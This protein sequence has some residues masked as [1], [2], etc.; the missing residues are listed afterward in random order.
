[1]SEKGIDSLNIGIPEMGGS[2]W[3]AGSIYTYN[4]V[5]A[6]QLIAE[7]K[8]AKAVLFQRAYLSAKDSNANNLTGDRIFYSYVESF[9]EAK[10]RRYSKWLISKLRHPRSVS[11]ERSAQKRKIDF[12]FPLGTALPLLKCAQAQW[13]PDF[14]H[15]RLPQYFPTPFGEQR[16]QIVD[17][18]LK[19]ADHIILSSEAARRDAISYS[20][21]CERKLKVLP[22]V[23]LPDKEWFECE[24]GPVARRYAG[25]RPFF[26]FPSQ[27]W[28][29]KGHETLIRAVARLKRSF[30]R[31]ITVLC[32]GFQLDYRFPDH[33]KEIENLVADLGLSEQ[34]RFLG[35]LPRTEQVQLVRAS[36]AVIQPSRFEGWSALLEDAQC[37]GKPIIATDLEVHREQN[38]PK[39]QYFPVGDS[40]ALASEIETFLITGPRGYDKREEKIGLDRQLKR[41]EDFANRFIGIASKIV[42]EHAALNRE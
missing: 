11:F 21:D 31:E 9:T 37:L 33:F 42:E 24:P 12:M 30:D 19:K 29:H 13:I 35:L 34:V 6:L 28:A 32:T 8:T 25:G 2:G 22:F 23:I 18:V 4:L 41:G 17:M 5:R 40:E 38:P 39:I 14:Q 20:P 27:V 36:L 16:K 1:M 15:L 26:I 10:S 7:P 3:V